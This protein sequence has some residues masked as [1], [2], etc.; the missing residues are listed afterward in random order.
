MKDST[1]VKLCRNLSKTDFK[2]LRKVVR[3]PYFNQ[4]ED[5]ISLFDY[6]ETNLEKGG[7]R[8]ERERVFQKIF[9]AGQ[10]FD[11]QLLRYSA[12]FLL[13][14]IREWLAVEEM[15]ADGSKE[16]VYVQ[17]ALKKLGAEELR[18]RELPDALARHEGGA[19]RDAVHFRQHFQLLFD[20]YDAELKQNRANEH[21]L[22]P[23]IQAM[24]VSNVSALLSMGC[25]VRAAQNFSGK[26][27]ELPLL[28][29]AIGYVEAGNFR[30]VPAVMGW[31]HTLR[32]LES[33]ENEADF[34]ALKDILLTTKNQFSTSEFGDLH[35]AAINFCI[36]RANQGRKDFLQGAFELYK[37]GFKSGALLAYGRLSKYTYKNAANLGIQLGE[38]DWVDG[39]LTD[40]KPYLPQG[41]RENLFSLSLAKASFQQKK[42]DDALL[43]LQEVALAEEPLYNLD[44]RRML[45]RIFYEQGSFDALDSQL[46][47]YSAYL[48]R[49]KEVGYYRENHLHFIGW[50]RK[51]MR[52]D[53]R[54]A[55]AKG[56]LREKLAG[57]KSVL[58]KDWLLEQLR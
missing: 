39:F 48:R 3:S 43:L 58:E 37:S 6:L 31:F 25:T 55:A 34:L 12:S 47:S 15:R 22:G 19:R 33:S 51:L 16:Q 45:V 8:L 26:N 54:N 30:E 10:P 49:H 23:V 28:D 44:A 35:L 2:K 1:L 42:Y 41:D 27:M 11:M 38:Y 29:A 32:C 14:T 20:E 50:I 40:F 53:L 52:A 24:T 56:R 18:L 57:E 17:R 9:P 36:R 46:D 13:N 7:E 21:R 4:R 5:V